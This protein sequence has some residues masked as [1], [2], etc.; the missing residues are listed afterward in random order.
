G[1]FDDTRPE[2]SGLIL[3]EDYATEPLTASDL[4]LLVQ[5]SA[6][7]I[8]CLSCCL[9]ARTATTPDWGHLRGMLEALARTDV[10]SVLGYRWMVRDDSARE[11]AL[12][13]Y[14]SLWRYFS[15]GEAML[16]ARH[17]AAMSRHKLD[18]SSW[19]APILLVQN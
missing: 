12:N 17:H 14:H 6:L 13:F 18:E 8:V 3:Y 16:K 9:G 4:S 11:L 5:N 2:V 15:P 7:Q 10:P 1:R 19:L